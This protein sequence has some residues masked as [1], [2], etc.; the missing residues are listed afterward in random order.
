[1]GVNPRLAFFGG[2]FA[3]IFAA[4]LIAV[5]GHVDLRETPDGVETRGIGNEVQLALLFMTLVGVVIFLVGITSGKNRNGKDAW[6]EE[7]HLEYARC[8]YHDPLDMSRNCPTC[9]KQVPHF[10]KACAFCGHQFDPTAEKT[11]D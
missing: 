7:S 2:Y 5:S 3:A 11:S 6:L 4:V 1:M 8:P 10:W 9:R